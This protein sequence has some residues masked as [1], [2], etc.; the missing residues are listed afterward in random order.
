[1]FDERDA[2]T[3][4]FAPPLRCEHTTTATEKW[5]LALWQLGAKSSWRLWRRSAAISVEYV[6]HHSR[7]TLQAHCARRD[8]ST[9][10][11][12]MLPGLIPGAEIDEGDEAA[13]AFGT[14]RSWSTA[15]FQLWNPGWIELA[16]DAHPS[17]VDGIISVLSGLPE[18]TSGLIQILLQPTWMRT[19]DGR[20]PAFWLAGRVAAGSCSM[21]AAAGSARILSGT[22]GQLTGF[23]G[24]RCGRIRS[25]SAGDQRA[26]LERRWIRTFLPP[27]PPATPAQVALLFHPPEAAASASLH[28]VRCAHTPTTTTSSSIHL[29]TGRDARG[30]AVETGLSPRDLLRHALVVGP[31]GTGKSTLLANLALS[32]VSEGNGV[33]VIDPHGSLVRD[34]ARALPE[35]RQNDAAFISFAD[36]EYPVSL[37]P[38][39]VRPGQ[40]FLAADELVEVVQRVYGS[41]YW[42]PL[43]DLT[44]RHAAMAA[45]EIGGSLLDSARLLDDPW[46]RDRTLARVANA[47]TVRVLGQLGSAGYDRRLL[48]AI[49]RLQRLL[50]TPW[51]RNIVGQQAPGIDFQ[52]VFDERRILL[53]DLSNVG[54]TNARLLG[55]LLLLLIRQATLGRRTDPAAEH[56]VLVDEAS[57]FVSR[58]VSELFDQARKFGVGIVLA[59]Q[60]LAQLAPADVRDAVLANAGSLVTFRLSDPDEASA[61]ARRLASE[62]I[63]A[64]DLRHLGS[65]ET[66]LQMTH[67]GDRL[68]AAW[69]RASPPAERANDSPAVL[70]RLVRTARERYA[71]PRAAVE[72]ELHQRNLQM[73]ADDEPEI[74][75]LAPPPALLAHTA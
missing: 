33:T 66:Y 55:S 48:P 70:S 8:L 14:F 46:F 75:S 21:R 20:Q 15:P 38:L 67:G 54:A 10:T 3:L 26:I 1:M 61:M 53:F 40:E 22:L 50:A 68:E 34:I 60:R 25:A 36:T 56:I 42:G 13:E 71:R 32:L 28:R 57:W 23:N 51:M 31:S 7:I 9:L 30:R 43:I 35:R 49:N 18:G 73:L 16:R 5:L 58:T 63:T 2:L 19:E 44:L 12:G 65:Y 62:R 59:V 69:M 47:E 72:A 41:E 29:G 11:T 6:A 4:R 24:L 27:G 52:A 64:D 37:N 74:R 39:R 45:A 17:A